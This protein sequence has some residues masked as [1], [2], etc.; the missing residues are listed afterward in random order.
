MRLSV[1]NPTESNSSPNWEVANE[2]SPGWLKFAIF[3]A[4]SALAGGIATAWWYR[5]TLSKLRESGEIPQNSDFGISEKRGGD[6]HPDG[7]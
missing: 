6:E 4:V 7:V 5:K 1:T 3:T 2:G